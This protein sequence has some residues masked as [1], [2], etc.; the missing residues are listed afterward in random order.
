MLQYSC[1][2]VSLSFHQIKRKVPSQLAQ[3][4]L[5]LISKVTIVIFTNYSQGLR[6]QPFY[7]RQTVQKQAVCDL[8]SL[9]LPIIFKQLLC[10]ANQF[11]ILVV[12][13]V[14]VDQAKHFEFCF[15]ITRNQITFRSTFFNF[16]LA[17]VFDIQHL[18]Q[19]DFHYCFNLNKVLFTN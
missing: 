14:Y 12:A 2:K 1:F 6:S 7:K 18:L 19:T 16:I 13:L 9:V 17:F 3:F 4:S 11:C 5:L 15:Q 8:Q 10:L